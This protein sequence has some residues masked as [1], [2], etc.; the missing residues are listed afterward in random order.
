MAQVQSRR[1]KSP[2]IDRKLVKELQTLL[3]GNKGIEVLG[4]L[5]VAANCCGNGT[6]ALVRIDKGRPPS[7]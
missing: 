6:V 1:K 5:G 2:A 3:K 7:K 4:H